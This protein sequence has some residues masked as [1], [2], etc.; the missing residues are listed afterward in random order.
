MPELPD[1]EVFKGYLDATALHQ[2]ITDVEVETAR[3]LE[4]VS[5]AKLQKTLKGRQFRSTHRHGKHLLVALDQGPWLTLHFG[6][7]GFLK[8]FKDMDK[9]PEH[10]R[11]LISFD[12]G[13]H[14]AYDSQRKLGAVGL[15][16]DVD[17]FIEEKELGPDALRLDLEGFR[18]VIKGRRGALKSFL[19]NQKHLAG[20]GNVYSDEILFQCGLHPKS[21]V[22]DLDGDT[23]KRLFEAMQDVLHRAIAAQADPKRF[24][25]SFIIPHREPEGTCPRCQGKVEKITVSGR[26]G[27]YCPKCQA[28]PG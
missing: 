26:S 11:L 22:N 6:M 13:Y 21:E 25:D 23:V 9:E 7:T 5:I 4:G 19:M 17:N 8:Y 20:I 28:K 2:T 10:D 16:E 3:I 14:L 18:Q 15:S 12:N 1:V 24:P 27:Y